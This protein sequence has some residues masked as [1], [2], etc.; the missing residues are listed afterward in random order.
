MFLSI[1]NAIA[2]SK[3]LS[4]FLLLSIFTIP[5]LVLILV[6]IFSFLYLSTLVILILFLVFEQAPKPISEFLVSFLSLFVF[7]A[8]ALPALLALIVFPSP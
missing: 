8:P 3:L 5:I 4:I 1:L 7:I 6:L 2:S